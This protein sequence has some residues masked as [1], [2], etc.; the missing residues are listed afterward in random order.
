MN[1]NGLVALVASGGILVAIAIVIVLSTLRARRRFDAAA[2]RASDL[3]IANA[4]DQV[5]A[6]IDKGRRGY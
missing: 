4:M 2:R 6:E 3:E 5:Q 1:I